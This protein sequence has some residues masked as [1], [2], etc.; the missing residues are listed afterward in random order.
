MSFTHG[1]VPEPDHDKNA[2]WFIFQGDKLLV[3]SPESTAMIPRSS[4]ITS[5]KAK[6]L[7]T[8]YLGTL[9]GIGC[10]VAEVEGLLGDPEGMLFQE[11]RPL[12]G[13]LSDEMFSLAGRAYQILYW[14]RTHQFCSRCG[15]RTHQK[16]DE[17]A[18]ECLLCGMV[19]YPVIA[20]AII[21]AVVKG[22]EILLARARRFTARFYSVL[23]GFVEAGETFEECVRREIK[24]EVGLDVDNIAYFGNQPWP[25]PNS[26]M[27][28][29]TAEYA[30]GEIII[31][32]A[33]IV[34]AQWYTADKLP[35]VPR[36][37]TIARRLIDWFVENSRQF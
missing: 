7:R 18:K 11:F 30:G 13:L 17:R 37:G 31:D 34:D 36:K 4:D 25:F 22:Q 16:K 20:P 29:F 14:D 32:T 27:V 33:E 19:T 15:A 9:N 6:F 5:F 10:F 8:H 26:L 3:K 12:L 2:W 21:V 23:A 35:E 24:E 28:A 1:L